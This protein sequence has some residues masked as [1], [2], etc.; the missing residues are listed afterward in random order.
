MLTIS[1]PSRVHGQSLVSILIG[2]VISLLTIAAMLALYRNLINTSS[3]AARSS[4]RDGN[5]AS[6]VTSARIYLQDAGFGIQP[7][8]PLLSK[9]IIS[10]AGK[11]VVWRYKQILSDK[12]LCAGL[13]L[14]DG[15]NNSGHSSAQGLCYLQP[16]ACNQTSISSITWTQAE[17]TALL[18]NATADPASAFF[19]TKNPNEATKADDEVGALTLAP[20]GADGYTFRLQA[21][22][23]L[24][25]R[26]QAGTLSQ[27]QRLT[28]AASD[29]DALFSICLP[30]LKSL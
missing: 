17:R 28:L 10:Q 7:T 27:A 18:A 2:I 16:K 25:Y 30:N 12:D 6:A 23:C 11:Q 26:Q 5:V 15:S 9:L 4:L 22:N 19:T 24:P 3:E 1:Y 29:R 8:E 20:Q 14:I 13:Q 21:D